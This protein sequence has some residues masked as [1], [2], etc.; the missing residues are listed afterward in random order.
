MTVHEKA[1]GVGQDVEG[2]NQKPSKDSVWSKATRRARAR[3]AQRGMVAADHR[4]VIVDTPDGDAVV[5][6]RRKSTE[7]TPR[8]IRMAEDLAG[9][10]IEIR[11]TGIGRRTMVWRTSD[12]G[13]W[14]KGGIIHIRKSPTT[15]ERAFVV[16]ISKGANAND[17]KFLLGVIDDARRGDALELWSRVTANWADDQTFVFDS[18]RPYGDPYTHIDST[19][20][21]IV[22]D[23]PRC[24]HQWHD[25]PLHE[26]DSAA[27]EGYS[28]SVSRH[29]SEKHWHVEVMADG[30]FTPAELSVFVND[31][32]WMQAECEK[33]NGR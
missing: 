27:G 8:E 17:V 22:C 7:R 18:S 21:A 9:L 5:R 20:R 4:I 16:T 13:W 29:R 19:S 24:V 23:D 30:E 31:L 15:G 14:R 12:G 2:E 11:R 10:P 32:Q 28:I 33:A 26:L 25:Y 1:P 6:N 3:N